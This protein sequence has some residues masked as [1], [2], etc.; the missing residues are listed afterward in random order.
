MILAPRRLGAALTAATLMRA[1]LIR[2]ALI[3]AAL[4]VIAACDGGGE[5]AAPASS[6]TPAPALTSGATL[7]AAPTPSPTS[8]PPPTPTLALTPTP[9]LTP[10]LVPTSTAAPTPT[11]VLTLTPAPTPTPASSVT[12]A[13]TPTP[14][15][16]APRFIPIPA[17]HPADLLELTGRLRL[18]GA[19]APTPLANRN[20][21]HS[22]GREDRFTAF[23]IDAR[24]PFPVDAVLRRVTANVYFYI[25]RGQDVSDADLDRSATE[26]EERIIPSVRR[27][28]NPAWQPGAGIDSRVTILHARIPA[29][30]GYYSLLDQLPV[31]VNKHSNE[32]PMVFI[33]LDVMRPGTTAYYGVLT[34]E[35]QHAAQAQADPNEE[36]WVHEGSSEYVSDATGY[37]VGFQ[38]YFY[39][40]PDTQLTTWGESANESLAHY[41]AGHLF[42]R[43][44][45]DRFGAA[46]VASLISSPAHGVPGMEAFLQRQGYT[47]GFDGIF[48]DWLASN[49]LHPP[50]TQPTLAFGD[51]VASSI[52]TQSVGAGPVAATVHQYG[53]DYYSIPAQATSQRVSFR[54]GTEVQLL[55]ATA[56]SGSS[57]YWSNRGD[58]IDSTLTRAFDLRGV[59]AATLTFKTWYRIEEHYDYA[60][61]ELSRDGGSTWEIL[62]GRHTTTDDPVNQ[63]YGAAYTGRSGGGASPQWVDERID[64][65]GYA[66]S[67]V[68]VRFEYVT[69]MGTNFE[70]MAIDD[71]AIE[72]IGF[73]DNA[74]QELGWD[75][76]GF[77]RTNNN[78]PQGFTVQ[79]LL[80][81]GTPE[82]IAMALDAD[83]NGTIVVPAN[84]EAVLVVGAMAPVTTVEATYS[85]EVTG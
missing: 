58:T 10:S 66:G 60:Y 3:G 36:V 72:E 74:E 41:G 2:V 71:I 22:V 48:A 83:N 18:G 28:A 68:L 45:S 44:L 78:V 16:V 14:A 62:P 12:P 20:T 56:A 30:A 37:P 84:M 40:T 21:Q 39:G 79:L 73:L 49:Y 38:L 70:G 50:V 11:A 64:L 17:P 1:T 26:V 31:A 52:R 34:H 47:R 32:R 43:Y 76:L 27:L 7:T 54:G 8:A 5:A 15:P 23:D 63:N 57:F 42:M 53:A 6:V 33:S 75:A 4:F 77:V 67:Q 19:P 65:T 46:A 59:S 55:P 80:R 13:P 51:S 69:D 24:R 85:Y 35:F 82:T 81:G 61:V 9:A 25:E 29:V